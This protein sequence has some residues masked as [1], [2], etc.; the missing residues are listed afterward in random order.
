M[1][2]FEKV[3]VDI[4]KGVAYPFV[5]SAQ[6]IAILGTALKDEPVV[7]D[8]V[9]GLISQVGQLTAEGAIAVTAKGIDLPDDV[10]TLVAAKSLFTYVTLTFLPAVE[11]A[12]KD[13]APEIKGLD[14]PAPAPDAAPAP[15]PAVV[16]APGLHTVT[17][18]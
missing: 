4:G 5:H 2:G 8:A 9:V 3:M 13:L 18:A 12:Y 16:P 7:K 15:A 1:N 14:Q 11:G 10:A 6:L 17:P